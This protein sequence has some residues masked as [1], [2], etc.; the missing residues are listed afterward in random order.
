MWTVGNILT[1]VTGTFLVDS[2]LLRLCESVENY[3]S[4]QLVAKRSNMTVES[5][6]PTPPRSLFLCVFPLE[7]RLEIYIYLLVHPPSKRIPMFPPHHGNSSHDQRLH[8]AILLTNRQINAEGTPILY[9]QNTF[10]AHPTMLSDFPRL[11]PNFPPVREVTVL[12]QI[13]RFLVRV[14]LDCDAN[15]DRE[16]VTRA[17][18]GVEELV[19]D[20]WQAMFLG[21]DN[22]A[23]KVFEGVRGVRRARVTGSTTG[24][25]GYARWLE[26]KMESPLGKEMEYVGGG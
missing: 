14:R 15:V 2:S 13:R 19:V 17:F 11:R 12:P 24:F 8:P 9:G 16:A 23:L 7:L 1:R 5:T 20:V 4:T 26:G 21:A 6:V 18:S 3:L 25:D 22:E 10:L